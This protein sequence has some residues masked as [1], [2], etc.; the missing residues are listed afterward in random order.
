[1][2]PQP[3]PI[4]TCRIISALISFFVFV[5]LSGAPSFG[6][7][8][9]PPALQTPWIPAPQPVLPP[10]V[11]NALQVNMA[12]SVGPGYSP[13]PPAMPPNPMMSPTWDQTRQFIDQHPSL[14]TLDQV[15]K[16]TLIYG[17]TGASPI[18]SSPYLN[19][20]QPN[21]FFQNGHVVPNWYVPATWSSTQMNWTSVQS[22][23]FVPS[24]SPTTNSWSSGTTPYNPTSYTP[25]YRPPVYQPPQQ[26]PARVVPN[27]SQ[28][29]PFPTSTLATTTG[30]NLLASRP[31]ALT[32]AIESG[33]RALALSESAGDKVGQVANHAALAQLLVQQ[34]KLDQAFLHLT[35]AETMTKTVGDPRLQINVLQTKGAAYMSSGEF[36][37][38]LDAYR[39][40]MKLSRSLNDDASQA[41]LFAS[42]GWAFQSLG[43]VP[44]A[45]GCYESAITLFT[46]VGNKDGEVRTR[47]GIGSLY[48]SI[49]EPQ[50][51]SE[52]Y[53]KAAPSASDEQYARML[54]SVAE[55]HQ[56]QNQPREALT[57]YKK[58]LSLIGSTNDPS[59]E[60]AIWTGMARSHMTSGSYLVAQDYFERARVKIKESGNRAAEAGIIASI[61]ELNYWVA[62]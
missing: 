54:I 58:A 6:Q 62:I 53:M 25:T 61:G 35:V 21:P 12:S 32:R 8:T 56:S 29:R 55:I 42:S 23:G 57:R 41:E 13:P 50:K 51:A 37:K 49:G 31:A 24:A 2:A 52:Q 16:F 4:F 48:Q 3:A 44:R 10:Q 36:E 7:A 17:G 19:N 5:L 22:N 30:N 27:N 1:M 40:A 20:G 28:L 45:L 34:G 33:E 47:I 11:T 14:R 46:K 60:G 9:T 59:L 39:E 43:N 38:S 26:A 18:L 15:T